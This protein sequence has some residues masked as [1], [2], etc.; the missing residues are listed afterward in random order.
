LT[1]VASHLTIR[2]KVSSRPHAD[3]R[4][5]PFS[6]TPATQSHITVREFNTGLGH[7]TA[8]TNR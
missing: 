3:M 7:E 8:Q 6:G 1:S 5:R 2:P 4:D